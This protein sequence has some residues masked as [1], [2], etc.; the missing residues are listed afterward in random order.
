MKNKL[1]KSGLVAVFSTILTISFYSCNNENDIDDAVYAQNV[2]EIPYTM[3]KC[4]NASFV[5]GLFESHKE[6]TRSI[7]DGVISSGEYDFTNSIKSDVTNRAEDFYIIPSKQNGNNELLAGICVNNEIVAIF[8]FLK[9]SDSLYTLYNEAN[10]PMY[11]VEYNVENHSLTI[12]GE[13]DNDAIIVTTRA[14]MY[15]YAC[16]VAIGAGGIALASIGAIPTLGASIGFLACSSLLSV[17]I[18]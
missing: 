7:G 12:I 5:E 13:Y 14:S 6:M 17:L 10:E 2:S 18:C 15:S 3:S 1:I 9:K 11:D 4:E 8:K 16:S